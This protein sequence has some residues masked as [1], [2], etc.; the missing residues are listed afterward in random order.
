[1]SIVSSLQFGFRPRLPLILQAEA[2]ECGLASL[3]M[4]AGFHGHLTD[5]AS[6]RKRF[7]LSLKGATLAHIIRAAG[8]LDLAARPLRLELDELRNLRTPCILHWDLSHFVVLKEAGPRHIEIHD[9]AHGL[10][11]L[12]YAEASP[13]FTG[14]AL[15]LSPTPQFRPAEERQRIRLADLMG[16]VVGLKRSVGQ[17]LLLAMCLEFFALLSPFYMQLV[18]DNAIVAADADFLAVLALGFG[19]L[20]LVQTGL[21]L[22]RSWAILYLGTTMNV[23]WLANVFSHLVRLPVPFFERRHI[24]D[25]VSRFG[26][27]NSI[28]HT[29]TGSFL[30]AILD[31]MMAIATVAMMFHYSPRLAW[32][33][34]AGV[35][36]YATIRAFAYGPLRRVNEEQIVHS[37]RQQSTFLETLR[38][39]QSLR[40]FGREDE[41]QVRWLNQVTDATNSSIRAQRFLILYRGASGLVFGLENVIVVYLGAH[42]VLEGAFSAGMLVAYMAYKATFSTRVSALVDKAFEFRM[43]ELHATRLADIV[44]Q[45]REEEDAPAAALPADVAPTLEIRD[46]TFRYA[47]GEPNVVDG[48]SLSIPA[49][50]C[51]A[52]VG[53]SGCGKTTL[54]KLMLGLFPPLAGEVLVGGVGI[55]RLGLRNYRQIIASV[56]QD[57]QLFAGSIGENIAFFAAE[58]DPR[59]IEQCARLAAIHDEIVRMPMGYNTLIGDMGTALS[60]GQKQRILLARA[61]YRR[62]RILFLDEATSHLD[63]ASERAVNAALKQ[64]EITRVVVAHRP[65]TIAMADRVVVLHGGKPVKDFRNVSPGTVPA[66]G[67]QADLSRPP[68]PQP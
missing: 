48:C 67:A 49:G 17:V 31:G 8:I 44:L 45:E 18:L 30:E 1:M 46:A 51:V 52:I 61:L 2:A 33:S 32:I 47:D 68:V 38:G 20:L 62:P 7:S 10:R 53:P 25:L 19:L 60:G 23:Q 12:T 41:R 21:A 42:L 64:L 55:R 58:H 57:D 4:V 66:P 26:S 35:A 3:A 5:L 15:E 43:L 40:L 59:W 63:V 6:L 14:V 22:V 37:A 54:L 36:L 50:E 13:H 65:E 24:G 28:Q 34:L 29:L 39:I 9:P 16:R 27:I 56:M 11:R